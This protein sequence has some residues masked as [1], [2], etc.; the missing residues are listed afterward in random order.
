MH[1]TEIRRMSLTKSPLFDQ[2]GIIGCSPGDKTYGAKAF[3]APAKIVRERKNPHFSLTR[4]RPCSRRERG[5]FEC[6][7][8]A[9]GGERGGAGGGAAPTHTALRTLGENFPSLK[10]GPRNAPHNTLTRSLAEC[11]RALKKGFHLQY[12]RTLQLEIWIHLPVSLC[13]ACASIATLSKWAAAAV[14][15]VLLLVSIAR[16][17]RSEVKVL[18]ARPWKQQ[19]AA[20][21]YALIHRLRRKNNAPRARAGYNR[22]S[23]D[24]RRFRG[25]RGDMI[26]VNAFFM[27]TY[28][29]NSRP[30]GRIRPA[31]VRFD[32]ARVTF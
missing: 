3:C 31:A 20:L 19:V 14:L 12:H 5:W 28:A 11:G 1:A 6:A 29:G 23:A 27:V 2:N 16:V 8:P 32:P 7:S 21:A 26:Y 30:A 10:V 25:L 15:A 4:S 13:F 9:G 24:F 22:N 18:G 17:L